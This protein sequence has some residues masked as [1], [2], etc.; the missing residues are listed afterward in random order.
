MYYYK[1][2]IYSPTL[3]RFMQ[4]DPIGY[5]DQVNLYAYVG[6]DPVN[7]TDPTG[8][9]LEIK[10][11]ISYRN[12]VKKDI[13]KLRTGKNGKALI[14]KLVESKNVITIEK[15]RDVEVG[16][17]AKPDNKANSMNGKGSGSTIHFDPSD[18]TAPSGSADDNGSTERPAFVALGHELGHS[19][20]MDLGNQS[21]KY[22]KRVEGTTPRSEI[23]SMANERAIRDEHGLTQRSQYYQK[24][25]D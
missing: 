14:K 22:G 2:R 20:S 7:A 25:E 17:E 19:R 13:A 21:Y 23:H 9:K 3:G 1:A 4:T 16:N 24:K 18:N 11:T 10:G 12:A 6:N 15:V 8:L 5:K